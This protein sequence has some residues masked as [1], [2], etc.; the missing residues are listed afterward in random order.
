MGNH[1][2]SNDSPNAICTIPQS[3]PFFW[4]ETIPKWSLFMAARAYHITWLDGG[5]HA[6]GLR[7]KNGASRS[8]RTRQLWRDESPV[9]AAI[10]IWKP[11]SAMESLRKLSKLSEGNPQHSK[12][13]TKTT[14]FKL[15][16][17]LWDHRRHVALDQSIEKMIHCETWHF[18]LS[19]SGSIA[20][21]FGWHPILIIVD[22][23]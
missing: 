10:F 7:N 22:D 2:P 6:L 21:S 16:K 9:I 19:V 12:P 4:V 15:Q 8:A 17:H 20:H 1:H 5:D 13:Q 11:C 3:S 18:N 23:S 14:R